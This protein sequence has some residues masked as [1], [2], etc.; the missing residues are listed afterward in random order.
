LEIGAGRL[1][2]ARFETPGAAGGSRAGCPDRQRV[3]RARLRGV[4]L[5]PSNPGGG[6]GGRALAEREA[7]PCPAGPYAPRRRSAQVAAVTAGG[8]DEVVLATPEPWAPACS[9][10]G[11]GALWRKR[12]FWATA[13]S[14]HPPPRGWQQRGQFVKFSPSPA[15]SAA[16]TVGRR[17]RGRNVSFDL[18]SARAVAGRCLP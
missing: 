15:A 13:R 6:G 17:R 5:E 2:L 9:G 16:S 12:R 7:A 10:G 1:C 11:S 18:A 3:P 8:G 4:L 14:K